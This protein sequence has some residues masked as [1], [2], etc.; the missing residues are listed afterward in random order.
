MTRLMGRTRKGARNIV[1]DTV[2]VFPTSQSFAAAAGQTLRHGPALRC[3]IA[4]L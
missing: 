1:E 2:T 4:S 3:R